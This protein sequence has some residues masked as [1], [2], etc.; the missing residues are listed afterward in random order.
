M[1]DALSWRSAETVTMSSSEKHQPAA[2]IYPDDNPK[3]AVGSKKPSLTKFPASAS[4]YGAL[5]MMNGAE[6]YGPYNWREKRV[7]ASIYVDAAKRHLDAWYDGETHSDDTSPPVPHL[8]HAIASIA[9][10]IDALET[11]NLN[12]D[13]P[14]PGPAGRMIAEWARKIELARSVPKFIG[15]VTMQMPDG[16][17]SLGK[18]IEQ[19][20]AVPKFSGTV[21]VQMPDGT[22]SLG[23]FIEHIKKTGGFKRKPKQARAAV[24]AALAKPKAKPARKRKR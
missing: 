19:A 7:T 4:I 20:R 11:G 12:D 21:T 15:T 22:A 8:A 18:F 1:T 17:A 14:L 10:L 16:A 23:K 9:I 6:K 13:R 5:A 3:T 2:G 24:K